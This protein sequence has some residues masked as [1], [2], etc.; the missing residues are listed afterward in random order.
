MTLA[1]L[2]ARAM[3]PDEVQALTDALVNDARR[4]AG[5]K[6]VILFGSAAEGRMTEASDIDAVLIFDTAQQ[7][8]TAQSQFYQQRVFVWPTD[9]ICVD[10][11]LFAERS[12][13][14]GIL[15]VAAHEG[16]VLF[17]RGD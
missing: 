5:L 4:H 8:R 10:E 6:R 7:A 15:Y 9:A 2:V 17:D 13:V 11:Q 12:A 14:G 16:K 3:R 1:R